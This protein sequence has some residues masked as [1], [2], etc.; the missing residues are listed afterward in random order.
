MSSNGETVFAEVTRS[1]SDLTIAFAGTIADG[2]YIVL[3]TYV[4]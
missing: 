2:S 3:L 4:G 1:G